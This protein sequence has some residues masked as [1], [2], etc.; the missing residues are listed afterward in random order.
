MQNVTVSNNPYA[1]FV[2]GL[3]VLQCL[4]ETPRRIESLVR[5]WPREKDQ[6]SHAPGKW[7]AGQVLTHLAQIEIVFSIRLR[8]ALAQDG[9]V[10]QPFEQDDW[11][12][13]E[14]P[15]SALAALDTY[16]ALRRMNLALC[17]SLTSAQR[18]KTFTHPEF[19]VLDV[20]WLMAWAAGHERN[21]APQIEA[22]AKG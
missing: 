8:F 13:N 15:P 4:E 19:G 20:D 1:K 22:V 6:H 11:M 18:A 3:D 16:V 9:Y 10:V 12:A 14:P 2:E 17:R 5:A 7:T 21:H